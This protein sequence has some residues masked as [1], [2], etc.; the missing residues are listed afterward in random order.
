M[1]GNRQM[2]ARV[3]LHGAGESDGGRGMA[4]IDTGD[5][6]YFDPDLV[7]QVI[8]QLQAVVDDIQSKT[9]VQARSLLHIVNPAWGNEPVTASFHNPMQASH[10]QHITDLTAWQHKIESDIANLKA[11]MTYYTG[12]D[13]AAAQGLTKKDG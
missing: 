13:Y 12:A 10:Q 5:G 9:L 6:T 1:L 8:D 2:T 3:Y 4:R 11:A 7:Q